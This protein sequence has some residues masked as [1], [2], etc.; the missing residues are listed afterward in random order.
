MGGTV[1]HSLLLYVFDDHDY[2]PLIPYLNHI[3]GF[4]VLVAGWSACA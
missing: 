3:F 4:I 1:S 2:V